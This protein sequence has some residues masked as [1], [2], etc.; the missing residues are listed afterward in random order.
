MVFRFR[1]YAVGGGEI[2]TFACSQ[3]DWRPGERLT[4][5]DGRRFEVRTFTSVAGAAIDGLLEVVPVA[6]EAGSD[7]VAIRRGGA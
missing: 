3:A 4:V 1:L 2:T 5:A 7:R 6:E